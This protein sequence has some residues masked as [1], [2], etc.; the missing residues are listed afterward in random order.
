MEPPFYG[1]RTIDDIDVEHVL[2]L[3]NRDVL[4]AARWQ[5]RGELSREAWHVRVADLAEPTFE[6]L[7]A[8]CLTH[9]TIQPR[10][11]YGHFHCE[12][13]GNLLFVEHLN[14]KVS[15]DFPR[16]RATPN[17]C[18]ADFFS[19]GFVAMQLVTVG[20]AV[21]EAGAK[22]FK[23]NKYTDA[24]YLKGLAAE[25][26]EALANYAQSYIANELDLSDDAGVRFSFGYP[27]CP[28]LM[29]QKKLYELLQ[30]KR[31]GVRLS[32]TMHLIPEHSTSAIIS[33]DDNAAR[34]IP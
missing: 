8:Y 24:F 10:I 12:Q 30:P 11:V 26:T 16:E 32:H 21:A 33:F 23:E 5:L 15:F 14:R 31:I 29:Y 34:F 20:N 7:A 19:D 27:P 9:N 17:R 4:F 18:L 1:T 2:Q 3:I 25:A 28:N 13:K 22:F 6:K